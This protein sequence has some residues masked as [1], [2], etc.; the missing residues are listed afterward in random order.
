MSSSA[1]T[2]AS[3]DLDEAREH[4][5]HVDGVMLGRA[6]YQHPAILAGVDGLLGRH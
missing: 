4:L 6:A 3:R 2:A 5:R 1:S